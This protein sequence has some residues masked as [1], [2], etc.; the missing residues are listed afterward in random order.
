[1]GRVTSLTSTD[2]WILTYYQ[3]IQDG[4]VTVG[5]WIRLW[6]EMIVHG[7]E[8]KRWSFDQKKANAAINFI[9]RYCHHHEGPLAP[10]L[11]KLEVWQNFHRGMD[12]CSPIRVGFR[13]LAFRM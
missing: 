8:E 6:Y 12:R 13:F 10:G 7:L 3:Q 9:E 5:K 4:S 2:N 1:M 11:L